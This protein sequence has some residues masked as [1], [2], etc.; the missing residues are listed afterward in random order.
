MVFIMPS[1]PSQSTCLHPLVGPCAMFYY[2]VIKGTIS[3]HLPLP[4]SPELP[5]S[6]HKVTIFAQELG[7]EVLQ[8]LT[9]VLFWQKVGHGFYACTGKQ[10]SSTERKQNAEASGRGSMV[11]D[12]KSSFEVPKDLVMSSDARTTRISE[13]SQVGK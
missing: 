6:A 3:R 8:K 11:E 10:G 9:M 7:H 12:R 5:F 2:L 1:L 13:T 4:S